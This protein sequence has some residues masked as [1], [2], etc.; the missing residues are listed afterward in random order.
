MAQAIP[1]SVM[2]A[3]ALRLKHYIDIERRE[4]GFDLSH[5]RSYPGTF[6]VRNKGGVGTFHYCSIQDR[7]LQRY[8]QNPQVRKRLLKSGMVRQKIFDEMD[9]VRK[10][11]EAAIYRPKSGK[12][13]VSHRQVIEYDLKR[14]SALLV[15]SAAEVLMEKFPSTSR[16][17]LDERKESLKRDVGSILSGQEYE[18]GGQEFEQD[19]LISEGSTQ[20]RCPMCLS[21]ITP[22][23]SNR[24]RSSSSRPSSSRPSSSRPSS[25]PS[26][27]RPVSSHTYTPVVTP[28][29]S[30]S[31]ASTPIPSLTLTPRSSTPVTKY[32]TPNSSCFPGTASPRVSS[33]PNSDK[34]VR[35][36]TKRRK[37][38][39]ASNVNYTL[40]FL[41]LPPH[42]Q[43]VFLAVFGAES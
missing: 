29:L 33:K 38:S 25:R 11:Y 13:G 36:S 18:K 10:K 12:V 34:Q 40:Y 39:C 35:I 7:Y 22:E 5:P 43:Y 1:E 21:V 19:T 14:E 37:S 15:E 26:S 30:P 6:Q 3:V 4:E 2:K 42:P 28:R 24:N 23:V 41:S 32:R 16:G 31:H 8:F 17:Q 20:T 9:A 27:S